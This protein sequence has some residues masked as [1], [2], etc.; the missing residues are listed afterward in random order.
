MPHNDLVTVLEQQHDCY[1]VV[2]AFGE[3]A[4]Y[5]LKYIFGMEQITL[6]GMISNITKDNDDHEYVLLHWFMNGRWITRL[7]L[8]YTE[9]LV[10][11]A[12]NIN[13]SMEAFQKNLDYV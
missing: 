2:V 5:P 1:I 3:P 13:R 6:D 7:H 9:S 4:I 10:D 11:D 12:E 8:K